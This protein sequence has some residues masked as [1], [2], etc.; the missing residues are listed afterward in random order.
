MKSTN[1][2]TIHEKRHTKQCRFFQK[3]TCPLSAEQCDFAHVKIQIHPVR[4]STDRFKQIQARMCGQGDYFQL[5]VSSL[6]AEKGAP[7]LASHQAH[8]LA[9]AIPVT[10]SAVTEVP[11]GQSIGPYGPVLLF[12]AAGHPAVPATSPAFSEDLARSI[13]RGEDSS[14]TSDVPS[15]SDGD[16]DPPSAT[17]EGPEPAERW[18]GSPTPAVQSPIVFYHNL[19]PG[20]SPPGIPVTHPVYGPWTSPE[21]VTHSESRRSGMSARKLKALKTKQCKFFKKDGRCPQGSVCTFIHDPSA[22]RAYQLTRG[23][24][25]DTSDSPDAF[26]QPSPQPHPQDHE[27]DVFPITWRV[28][29]GGVMMGGQREVCHRFMDGVC[30][31]GDDCPYA[32]PEEDDG[33]TTMEGPPPIE[34]PRASNFSQHVMAMADSSTRQTPVPAMPI[35]ELIPDISPIVLRG[36]GPLSPRAKE[37]LPPRPFSTPPR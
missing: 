13:F 9:D 37:D 3:G 11:H 28:I 31:D 27:R 4:Y 1:H 10:R 14:P 32:H 34:T 19:T 35:P 21:S 17:W 36:R 18:P 8:P 23:S 6:P 20:F 12:P 2:G 16:S 29:G 7:K 33:Q 24:P 25:S 15:L 30:Q 26:K 5:A 22:L